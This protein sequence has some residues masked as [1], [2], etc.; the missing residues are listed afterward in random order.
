[1]EK[2][3]HTFLQVTITT[4]SSNLQLPCR[5]RFILL[6][7]FDNILKDMNKLA[8]GHPAAFLGS[9]QVPFGR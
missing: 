7:V 4:L 3:L 2:A 5:R 9:T 8:Q 1:M 6:T